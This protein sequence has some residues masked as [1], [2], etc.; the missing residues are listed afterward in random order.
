MVQSKGLCDVC[1]LVRDDRSLKRVS[2]CGMCKAW[3]CGRCRKR[4]DQRTI[5]AIIRRGSALVAALK[6]VV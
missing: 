2:Y 4:L 5:A 1:V 3:L 6:E